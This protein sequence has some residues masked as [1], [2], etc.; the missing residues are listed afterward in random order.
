MR[1]VQVLALGQDL[2]AKGGGRQCQAHAQDNR[3]RFGLIEQ[4]VR[5]Q[6]QHHGG[7]PHLQRT[8]AEQRPAHGPQPS[9]RKLQSNHEQQHHHAHFR[10][11]CDVVRVAQQTQY[12]WANEDAGQQVAWHRAHFQPLRQWYQK[13]HGQQKNDCRL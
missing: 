4:K 10:K 5:Q 1:L 7:K 13:H 12:R 11:A 2:Q 8:D 9:W 3:R 6:T